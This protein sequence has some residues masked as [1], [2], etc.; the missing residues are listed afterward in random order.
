MK[1]TRVFILG[2]LILLLVGTIGLVG[3]QPTMAADNPAPNNAI[4]ESQKN[5]LQDIFRK[6]E[7]LLGPLMQ[8]YS[9]GKVTLTQLINAEKFDEPAIRAQFA[10]AAQVGADIAVTNAKL[11]KEMR[12]V[13]SKDQLDSLKK[14]G[15]AV[16]DAQVDRMLFRLATPVKIK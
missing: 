3:T 11:R 13:L 15:S 14:V 12:A 2:A 4:S 5:Q 1:N 10:K 16:T 8:K 7:G 9:A 6:Y